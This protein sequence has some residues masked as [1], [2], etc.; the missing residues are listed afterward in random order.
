DYSRLPFADGT[1][2]AVLAMESLL[3]APDL[4]QVLGELRRVLRPGG[5][6]AMSDI[7]LESAAEPERV[8]RF[9]AAVK[10]NVLMT[11]PDWLAQLKDAGFLVEEFTQCG[12]RTFGRKAKLI[13]ASMQRR[14]EMAAEF[15]E[16]AVAKF[17]S[18]LQGVFLPRRDQ[19]GYIIIAAAKPRH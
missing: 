9:A 17:S 16:E 7:S 1:F 11:L 19:I 15:G 4:P 6:F 3:F 12:P 14:A 13:K 18:E 5:R 10:L 8:E 2:D